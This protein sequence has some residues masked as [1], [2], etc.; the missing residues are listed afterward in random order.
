MPQIVPLCKLTLVH[1]WCEESTLWATN[2]VGVEDLGHLVWTLDEGRGPSQLHGHGPWLV[3][4]VALSWLQ[5]GMV[6]QTHLKF[7]RLEP[8]K[9]GLEYKLRI[10]F[11]QMV[12]GAN[13][14]NMC[15]V[16]RAHALHHN[17]PQN[18]NL[19][20]WHESE[21]LKFPV[22]YSF[23]TFRHMRRASRSDESLGGAI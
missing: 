15:S 7:A 23:F 11:H 2:H 12:D 22:D 21:V 8:P 16:T 14:T 5:A 20:L 10:E 6:H 3:C 1:M 9:V 19:N 13:T 17:A 4:E 18:P